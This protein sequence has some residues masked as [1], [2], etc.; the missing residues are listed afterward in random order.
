[1]RTYTFL[2]RL[3]VLASLVAASAFMGG[4]KWDLVPH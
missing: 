4:W 1:M 3:C 2:F